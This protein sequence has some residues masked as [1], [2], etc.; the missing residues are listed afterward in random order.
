MGRIRRLG[1][2]QSMRL[3][4]RFNGFFSRSPSTDLGL[5][6]LWFYLSAALWYLYCLDLDGAVGTMGRCVRDIIDSIM[7]V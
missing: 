1:G 5:F 6:V 4:R 7:G 2:I 3:P